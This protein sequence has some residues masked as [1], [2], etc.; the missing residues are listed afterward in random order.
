MLSSTWLTSSQLS[1][2]AK[3]TSSGSISFSAQV[4]ERNGNLFGQ[5]MVTDT[6][7]GMSEKTLASLFT[8]FRQGDTSTARLYGGTGL[9]LTISR[10]LA[11]LM[12]GQLTLESTAGVGTRATL[13][14][15]LKRPAPIAAQIPQF[16]R[17]PI[18]TRSV[19]AQT[20]LSTPGTPAHPITPTKGAA[21]KRPTTRRVQ[22]SVD[23]LPRP[24]GLQPSSLSPL[25]ARPIDDPSNH[26]NFAATEPTAS[27]PLSQRNSIAILIIE[28]NPINQRIA[29]KTVQKLGFTATAADNG[30][31]A[32]DFVL[33]N[34]VDIILSDCQMPLM[35]GYEFTR[36]IRTSEPWCSRV[37]RGM[38][39]IPQDSDTPLNSSTLNRKTLKDIPIIAL[40]ASAI[41][42]DQAKCYD[43]G[44]SDYIT[45][46]LDA[47]IL[48]MKLVKWA[49]GGGGSPVGGNLGGRKASVFGFERRGSGMGFDGDGSMSV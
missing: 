30:K 28:D 18:Q 46:P 36:A 49:F 21:S 41:P 35:D 31:E 4:E 34:P 14:L 32:L 47:K 8:P 15:P 37:L 29:L 3:F 12:G 2:A 1:N 16:N 44:M 42:G 22:T 5:L 17:T 6:G 20:S 48:E 39:G 38:P 45:K 13:N 9:G 23:A 43:A 25:T 26:P 40:T 10:N 24:T 7:V 11:H 27:L 33:Q 19:S